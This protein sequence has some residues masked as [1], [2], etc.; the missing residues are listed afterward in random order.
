[1]SSA[2][3]QQQLNQCRQDIARCEARIAKLNGEIEYIEVVHAKRVRQQ[4]AAY[5]TLG[6]RKASVG[7]YDGF[8]SKVNVSRSF[9]MRMQELTYSQEAQGK[10]EALGELAAT[11]QQALRNKNDELIQEQAELSR[12]RIR[13]GGLESELANAQRKEEEE[14][15]S[16][17]NAARAA[18]AGGR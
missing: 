11:L 2:L 15:Q 14:R 7:R 4:S 5:Q 12:L 16:A 3:I 13:C 6:A 1:M 18:K 9:G 17:A 8:Q 10:A